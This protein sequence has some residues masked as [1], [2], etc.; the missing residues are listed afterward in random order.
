MGKAT[1]KSGWLMRDLNRASKR[2]VHWSPGMTIQ[3]C[4]CDQCV[5]IRKL[6]Q[7]EEA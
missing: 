3:R 1:I 5:A 2:A 6:I 4:P 7:K